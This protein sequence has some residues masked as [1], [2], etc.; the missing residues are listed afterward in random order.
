VGWRVKAIRG[1]TTVE[2]N[3][4]EAMRAAVEELLDQLE[5]HNPI[6][7]EDIVSVTFSVTPD[8]NAMFPAAVAR[9]RPGWDIVPLLDVQ[10]MQVEGALSHCIRLMLLLNCSNP[11]RRIV[12]PYL[13]GAQAL[14]PDWALIP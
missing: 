13:R 14:R 7:P 3:T 8:L 1:A 12:H 11:D 2:A 5:A 10:Q 9:Q 6:N 4:V